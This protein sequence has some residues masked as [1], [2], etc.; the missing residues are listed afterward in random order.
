MED[1]A[2]GMK[3]DVEQQTLIVISFSWTFIWIKHVTYT[4][5]VYDI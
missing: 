4:L 3:L 5:N 2:S 1:P